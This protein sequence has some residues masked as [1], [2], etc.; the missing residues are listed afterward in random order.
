MDRLPLLARYPWVRPQ[1]PRIPLRI[2]ALTLLLLI[3]L[4][5]WQLQ[6]QPRPRAQGLERVMAL[7]ALIQSFSATP[8]RPVPT[9]W[10][11]RLGKPLAERVWRQQRTPWWQLWSR[12]GDGGVVLALPAAALAGIPTASRPAQMLVVDDL[13]LL[14]P[15]P[16]TR[17]WLSQQ[18]SSRPR[19]LRGLERVCLQRLETSQAVFWTPTALAEIAGPVAPLL[20]RFQEGCLNLNLAGAGLAWSGEAA[21]ATGLLSGPGS[22]VAASAERGPATPLL[23]ASDVLLELRGSSLDLV[24]QS[25]LARQL[26][27]DPLAARYGMGP[28]Q[29]PLLRQAPFRLRVRPLASGPF[30]AAL[31]LQLAVGSDR[32]AWITIL[33]ALRSALEEQG[34]QIMATATADPLPTATWTREDGVVIGGWRWVSVRGAAPELQ[35]FLGPLPKTAVQESAL[36]EALPPE[37]RRLSQLSLRLQPAELE[38]RGL[39]PPALPAVIR[40]ASRLEVTALADQAGRNP[41][42]LSLLTGHLDL[43][44]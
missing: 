10:Q 27:R 38:E 28:A 29:L 44:P 18:L 21:A 41:D 33:S 9:L 2:T 13:L 4:P 26:I 17:Q 20:Q 30:Q 1:S 34:L 15:D 3:L 22:V 11:E 5:V 31:E 37:A 12:N 43:N 7:A 6:R 25:L 8:Q 16:L 42:P 40:S 14:A 35:F 32:K 19:P 24:L 36:A 23:L 39:L